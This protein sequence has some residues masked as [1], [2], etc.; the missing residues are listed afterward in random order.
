[1]PALER[2][3]RQLGDRVRFVG[4]DSQDDPERAAAFAADIGITYDL[5][6]DEL[7]DV[8]ATL[9]LSTIPTTLFLDADG[10]IVST[11]TGALSED[12][13]RAR[14]TALLEPAS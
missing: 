11:H 5:W 9:D 12:D 6:S 3:H 7:G 13:L 8:F 14:T 1:M 4:I 10:A 2:V